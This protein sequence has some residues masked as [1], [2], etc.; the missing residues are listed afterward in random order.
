[1]LA[2]VDDDYLLLVVVDEEVRAQA[3]ALAGATALDVHGGV[4]LGALVH[5]HAL[6]LLGGIAIGALGVAKGELVAGTVTEG[7]CQA[8]L[9][10]AEQ[11]AVQGDG[12]GAQHSPHLAG[13]ALHELLGALACTGKHDDAVGEGP[14][15]QLER[16]ERCLGEVHGLHERGAHPERRH[17]LAQVG[18]LLGQLALP[19]GRGGL[20][21]VEFGAQAVDLLV[22]QLQLKGSL[23]R[24]AGLRRA[25]CR[26]AGTIGL[27][28]CGPCGGGRRGKGR[29]GAVGRLA[30]ANT[31]T[32]RL[33][34]SGGRGG[35]GGAS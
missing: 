11:Q 26:H 28:R 30:R 22:Q 24:D 29:I 23:D 34:D 18:G 20:L 15:G 32:G 35:I 2:A 3:L 1:M 33:A 5:H 7:V 8:A 13:V 25:G 4:A 9:A 19:I 27:T 14:L 12:H 17:L 16:L 6:G 31:E 21:R 10:L